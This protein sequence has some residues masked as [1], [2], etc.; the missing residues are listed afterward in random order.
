ML[1]TMKMD[2]SKWEVGIRFTSSKVVIQT[3]SLCSLFT[4]AQVQAYPL[5][6]NAFLTAFDKPSSIVNL[7]LDQS[8]DA[9]R[10]LS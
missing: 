6:T 4:E 2:L 3:A 8:G 5:I 9:P 10:R 7:S 1:P